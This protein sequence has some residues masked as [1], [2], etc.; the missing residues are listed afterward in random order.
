[1][2]PLE[3]AQKFVERVVFVVVAAPAAARIRAKG[4][5]AARRGE[6]C[7][8]YVDHRTFVRVDDRSEVRQHLRRAAGGRRARLR[9]R[10]GVAGRRDVGGG[11]R[12]A[13]LDRLFLGAAAGERKRRAGK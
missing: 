5:L 12:R 11:G 4:R 8:G 9:R 7:R 10:R 6:L 3:A 2:R 13:R 1:R